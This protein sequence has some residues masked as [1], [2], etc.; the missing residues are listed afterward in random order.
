MSLQFTNPEWPG[1]VAQTCRG[2]CTRLAGEEGRKPRAGRDLKA[3]QES[4]SKKE[5]STMSNKVSLKTAYS[6]DSSSNV[7][8]E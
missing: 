5:C 3:N 1:R 6:D 7:L 2:N 4:I 8:M